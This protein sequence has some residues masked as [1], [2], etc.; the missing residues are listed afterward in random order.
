MSFYVLDKVEIVDASFNVALQ[1]MGGQIVEV[2]PKY[3][4]KKEDAYRIKVDGLIS[5]A[6]PSGFLL[7]ESEIKL[8]DRVSLSVYEILKSKPS[9]GDDEDLYYELLNK[10]IT[11]G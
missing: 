1:G 8:I 11:P 2:L 3:F 9:P 4:S 6:N 7:K 10:E 5:I